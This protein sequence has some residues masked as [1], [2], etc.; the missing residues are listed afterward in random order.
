ML[1]YFHDN[2]ADT[3]NY[4]GKWKIAVLHSKTTKI[5]RFVIKMSLYQYILKHIQ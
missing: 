2:S 3:N 5:I 4:L 1:S